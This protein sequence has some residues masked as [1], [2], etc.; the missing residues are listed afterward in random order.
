M[1][2]DWKKIVTEYRKELDST[3]GVFSV[4]DLCDGLLI[5]DATSSF[6][7]TKTT[8]D[9]LRWLHDVISHTKADIRFREGWK[10]VPNMQNIIDYDYREIE[11][12]EELVSRLSV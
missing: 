3:D 4:K 7:A 1:Q 11:K 12:L 6:W 5:N 9:V 2:N 10:D 8:P